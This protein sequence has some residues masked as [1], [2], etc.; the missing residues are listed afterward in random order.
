MNA[1]ARIAPTAHAAEVFDLA[2][3]EP[4]WRELEETGTGSPFQRYDWVD[5]FARATGTQA[6]AFVL[7]AGDRPVLLLPLAIRRSR[8][9]RVAAPI[10]GKHA[11]F[12]LPLLAPGPAPDP[13]G[14]RTALREAGARL[15]LDA[16]AF[17]DMPLAWAGRPNP[18]AEG[19]RPSPSNGCVL[20]LESDPEA[21][22]KRI[23]STEARK[24]MRSRERKL[25]E[26]GPV[27]FGWAR[28]AEEVDTV[29]SAFFEQKATRFA[30]LGIPDAFADPGIRAFVRAACTVG[31]AEGRPA[32]DLYALWAG[33][34]L[35]AIN[36]AA[37]DRRRCSGMFNSF[38][39]DPAVAK[40]GPGELL[41]VQVIAEQCRR[42]LAE[43]DLGVGEAVYKKAFC[44][45]VEPLVDV[46]LPV[47]AAGRLYAFA[48]AQL[49]Q[50]KGAIK[51]HESAMRLARRLQ[52]LLPRP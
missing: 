38:D 22:L 14:I 13:V 12:N 39:V 16:Y 24:K 3:V 43:F 5:A 6:R 26:I 1:H 9:L 20:T 47:S 44:D 29:L 10:G 36:G 31:L 19:G 25:A 45:R 42:G 15:G 30:Q 33:E 34:R 23:F 4:L 50:A 27:R 52:A 35:V 11:S 41:F 18:L 46:I 21:C 48:A 32:I 2:A 49:L 40:A 7:R 17:T 8:G 28:T 37:A 51:R